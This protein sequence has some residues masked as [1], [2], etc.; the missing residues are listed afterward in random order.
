MQKHVG[1]NRLKRSC[2]HA[3]ILSLLYFK[4]KSKHKTEKTH[5]HT[6]SEHNT[7][8]KRENFS[9]VQKW[10]DDNVLFLYV[11]VFSLHFAFAFAVSFCSVSRRSVGMLYLLLV[12]ALPKQKH[13]WVKA[14]KKCYRFLFFS[15]STPSCTKSKQNAYILVFRASHDQTIVDINSKTPRIPM[16]TLAKGNGENNVFIRQLNR[17][18][19][20]C[21]QR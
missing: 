15:V 7:R 12:F 6:Q 16:R 8:K 17:I 19:Y 11:V 20:E 5:T 3:D 2:L 4:P 1:N 10:F 9:T 21:R 13:A 18:V 14:N